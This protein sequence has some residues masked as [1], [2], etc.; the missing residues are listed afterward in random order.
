MSF[1]LIE[2]RQHDKRSLELPVAF[3]A[4]G[5]WDLGKHAGG[6]THDVTTGGACIRTNRNHMPKIN[7]PLILMLSPEIKT[8][9][10]SSNTVIQ[11]KGKVVWVNS[12]AKRFGVSFS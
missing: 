8:P 2:H 3:Y 12:G 11:I 9:F 6:Q 1:S 5:D 4:N 7:S 10:L